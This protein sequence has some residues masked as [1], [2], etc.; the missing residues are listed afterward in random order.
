[1][2]HIID[3]QFGYVIA[4][5]GLDQMIH[6]LHATPMKSSEAAERLRADLNEGTCPLDLK[7]SPSGGWN[8]IQHAADAYDVAL[9]IYPLLGK[10]KDGWQLA[11]R[12]ADARPWQ[13]TAYGSDFD[14]EIPF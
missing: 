8:P 2:Y 9:R 7:P 6:P 4:E 10:R 1:M 11:L 12:I 13:T 3:E 5:L 14:S